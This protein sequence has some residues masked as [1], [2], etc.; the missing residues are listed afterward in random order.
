MPIHKPPPA[1]RIALKRAGSNI[2]QVRLAAQ[3]L[4]AASQVNDVGEGLFLCQV[5]SEDQSMPAALGAAVA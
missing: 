1:R 5:R 2:G 3:L 4:A